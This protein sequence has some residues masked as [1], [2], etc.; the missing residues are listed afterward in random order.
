[1]N[2]SLKRYFFVLVLF[3][4]VLLC[5]YLGG[6]YWFADDQQLSQASLAQKLSSICWIAYSPS[7]FDPGD[8]VYPS[9]DAIKEDLRV[10]KKGGFSGIVTYGSEKTLGQVPVL[11][12][13]LGFEGVIMGIWDPQSSEEMENAV[14][15][16]KY[17][18]GYCVGNGGLNKYYD[19]ELLRQSMATLR[20]RTRRPVTTTEGIDLYFKHNWLLEVGDWVFP[21]ARLYWNPEQDRSPGNFMRHLVEEYAQLVGLSEKPVVIKTVGYPSGGG[22]GETAS[23][24]KEFFTLLLENSREFP[25][26]RVRFVYFEAF[27]QPWKDWHEVEPH[28]GLYYNDRSPKL[29]VEEVWGKNLSFAGRSGV[30][31]NAVGEGSEFPG[32]VLLLGNMAIIPF[33]G[34]RG[35]LRT[36]KKKKE[37]Q[38]ILSEEKLLWRD[39][40]AVLD[41]R[42][43]KT[44]GKCLTLLNTFL[45]NGGPLNCGELIRM[46]GDSA[47]MEKCFH[48]STGDCSEKR[49]YCQAYRTLSNH[50]IG[51]IRKVLKDHGIGDVLVTPGKSE[52]QVVLSDAITVQVTT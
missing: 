47:L 39:G 30:V 34:F 17:A 35:L 26:E 42:F 29:A 25:Y 21:D 7:Q 48:D 49:Q 28:W 12:K 52:W 18:D 46:T 27:D 50:R 8:G 44:H 37:L 22:E 19:E 43:P 32:W 1:M 20:L 11:A 51:P 41:I 40:D 2:I 10:L 3:N 6:R 4:L 33:M 23:R 14:S 16:K 36:Q 45:S 24:Q 5:G 38:I 9:V 15:M 31:N 13:E